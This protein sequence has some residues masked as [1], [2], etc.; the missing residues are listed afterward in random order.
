LDEGIS[1]LEITENLAP[2]HE[3]YLASLSLSK[4]L[5]K[6]KELDCD[7]TSEFFT[8]TNGAFTPNA[9]DNKD[10]MQFLENFGKVKPDNITLSDGITAEEINT[11]CAIEK[12]TWDQAIAAADSPTHPDVAAVVEKLKTDFGLDFI[13]D[14]SF[15]PEDDKIIP[16]EAVTNNKEWK[17]FV[18]NLKNVDDSIDLSD[19]I[20]AA[21]WD[22]ISLIESFEIGYESDIL[23]TLKEH[24]CDLK[25]NLE[26]FTYN[27]ATNQY[28]VSEDAS[29]SDK[30]IWEDFIKEDGLF[31]KHLEDSEIDLSDGISLEE[32]QVLEDLEPLTAEFDFFE[33]LFNFDN[34]T[35]G[36]D[37]TL[38]PTGYIG[39][40]VAISCGLLFILIGTWI[41]MCCKRKSGGNNQNNGLPMEAFQH[42]HGASRYNMDHM[43]RRLI[44]TPAEGLS[45]ESPIKSNRN[46]QPSLQSRRLLRGTHA[47]LLI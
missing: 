4:L 34:W 2:A 1:Q 12:D 19:G 37:D 14:E 29:E 15:T 28:I 47:R 38:A 35:A 44:R 17:D 7:L 41:Y 18:A 6:L 36:E 16:D 33:N 42:L 13:T 22:K 20:N 10:W 46:P 11:L 40:L 21:E 39:I 43:S 45:H 23:A 26:F 8:Y 32:F 5:N 25:D 3:K 27:R 31:D 9:A 30:K 24:G